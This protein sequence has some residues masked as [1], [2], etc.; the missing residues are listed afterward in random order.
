[1]AQ[2]LSAPFSPRPD[3]GDQG[4]SPTSGSLYDACFSLCLC[5][6][7]SLSLCVSMNE[8]IKSLKKK[9]ICTKIKSKQEHNEIKDIKREPKNF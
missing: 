1:M 5:L 6:S 9:E 8:Q 2:R 7:L 3:P 4:S